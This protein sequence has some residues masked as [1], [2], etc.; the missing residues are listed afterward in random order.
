MCRARSPK[1]SP[2]TNPHHS[3]VV[4]VAG[5]AAENWGGEGERGRKRQV[6][7]IFYTP[8]R[9]FPQMKLGRDNG[10]SGIHCCSPFQPRQ[11]VGKSTVLEVHQR[12]E[13][14]TKWINEGH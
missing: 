2:A 9:L 12:T 10:W 5:H 7:T 6:T 3:A 13:V 11:I 14:R 1:K 8:S 4:D